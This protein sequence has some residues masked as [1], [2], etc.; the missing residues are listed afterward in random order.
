MKIPLCATWA[1]KQQE[2]SCSSCRVPRPNENATPNLSL[3]Q[4]VITDCGGED[5]LGIKKWGGFPSDK[6]SK[7]V[8]LM[9]CL[10]YDVASMR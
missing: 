6:A 9:L 3:V 2:S 8:S 1:L 5:A 7:K 4:K 10:L